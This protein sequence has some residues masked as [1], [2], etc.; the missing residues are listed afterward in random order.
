VLALVVTV[1]GCHHAASGSGQ[2]ALPSSAAGSTP[3][4][5]ATP[6]SAAPTETAAGP[7]ATRAVSTP[8][9]LAG[10][11]AALATLTAGRHTS[12]VKTGFGYEAIAF[13]QVGHVTFWQFDTGWRQV[14]TSTYPYGSAAVGQPPHAAATGTVLAGMTDATFILNGAFSGD[15]SGNSLAYTDGA[16]GWGAIKAEADGNLISSGQG[17]TFGGLGLESGFYFVN[18]ELETADCSA[19]MPIAACG[20]NNRVLKFWKWNGHDF[21]LARR[22]GLAK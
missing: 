21:G 16:H 10:A 11:S 4:I 15:G 17:V 7:G 14:G 3:S 19:T 13:D 5:G 12:V 20:G 6:T 1:S 8:P 9:D 22:A 18:S 2:R